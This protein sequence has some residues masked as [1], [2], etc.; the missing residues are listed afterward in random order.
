MS[1]SRGSMDFMAGFLV[2]GLVGAALALLFA[3]ARGEE[4]REQIK[5]KGIELQHLAHDITADPNRFAEEVTS[6]GR[7][8]LDEQRTRFQQAVEEGKRAAARKKDELLTHLGAGEPDE[9]ID[10]G[11]IDA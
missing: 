11:E 7:A 6:K 9:G 5:E 3:P 8:V 4:V 10:L 2:G 1:D